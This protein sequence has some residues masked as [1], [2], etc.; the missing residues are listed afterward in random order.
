MQIT[1]S[2]QQVEV[3]DEI[4]DYTRKKAEKLPRFFEKIQA[5]EVLWGREGDQLFVEFLVNPGSRQPFIAREVG[6]DGRTLVDLAVDKLERQI[7]K[8]K[9]KSR[10]RAHKNKRPP[11]PDEGEG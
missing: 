3:P 11:S 10:T 9:E 6:D 7:T 2:G 1:I 8:H 4:Q 5:V